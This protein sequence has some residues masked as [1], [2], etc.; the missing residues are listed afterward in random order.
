MLLE[1]VNVMNH[2]NQKN[3]ARIGEAS[4]RFLDVIDQPGVHPLIRVA[5]EFFGGAR[6]IDG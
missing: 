3:E 2:Q 4:R 5:S 1:S 6:S